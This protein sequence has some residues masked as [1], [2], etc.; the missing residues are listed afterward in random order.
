MK[1]NRARMDV[2]RADPELRTLSLKDL[3]TRYQC[4]TNIISHARAFAARDCPR[5]RTHEIHDHGDPQAFAEMLAAQ[6]LRRGRG[7]CVFC[8][9]RGA[10]C[11]VGADPACNSCHGCGYDPI[12]GSTC[13]C[14][15]WR[16]ATPNRRSP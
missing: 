15:G 8:Q 11:A 7:V 13:D 16:C 12:D 5:C 6:A 3:A 14:V 1:Q 4:S 9:R 10:G 2:I